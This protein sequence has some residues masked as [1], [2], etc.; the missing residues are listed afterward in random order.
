MYEYHMIFNVFIKCVFTIIMYLFIYKF[1]LQNFHCAFPSIPNS[2]CSVLIAKYI[3]I[4][5]SLTFK[6]LGW[7]RREYT[8]SQ[9]CSQQHYLNCQN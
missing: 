4:N 5:N 3:K 8:H 6:E 7:G 9:E 2:K 1:Y